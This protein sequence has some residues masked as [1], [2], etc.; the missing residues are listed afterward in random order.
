M[1][2]CGDDSRLFRG[3]RIRRGGFAE[4]VCATENAVAL[5]PVNLSF[6]EAA[7]CLWSREDCANAKRWATQSYLEVYHGK[8]TE[9]QLREEAED[10]WV[11]RADEHG[12][13][14]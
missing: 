8:R 13:E 4:Y 1:R 7:A 11:R 6:E 10:L 9:A 12:C 2:R 5:K 14:L 3:R